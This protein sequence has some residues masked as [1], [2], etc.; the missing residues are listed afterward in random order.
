MSWPSVRSSTHHQSTTSGKRR[1]PTSCLSCYLTRILSLAVLVLVSGPL[2]HAHAAL[3]KQASG[4]V[5]VHN[6]TELQEALDANAPM[7]E[8]VEH[9]DFEEL[10]SSN[11]SV[12]FSPSMP[13][14]AIWVRSVNQVQNYMP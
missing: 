2:Q 7:V 6:V 8:I 5:Q 12:T 9:L 14:T 13:D 10:T 3:D 1:S 11:D 4:V